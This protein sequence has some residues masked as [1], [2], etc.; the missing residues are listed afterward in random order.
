[1]KYPTDTIFQE[2]WWLDAVAPGHW[3]RHE[4]FDGDQLIAWMPL[5][6]RPRPLGITH[7]GMPPLTQTL[8][9]WIKP[10]EGSSMRRVGKI[11]K[12]T[13]ELLAT[14]PNFDYF[15]QNACHTLE[16]T[17]PFHWAG[18]EAHVK[19]TYI[20]DKLNDLDWLWTNMSAR[21][22]RAI[23]KAQNAIKVREL[24]DFGVFKRLYHNTFCRQGMETP[25]DESVLDRAYAAAKS[26]NAVKMLVAEDAS[27]RAHGAVFL[28]YDSRATYYLMGGSDPEKRDSQSLSLLLWESIKFSSTV[29]Q[30]FD[31]EGSM[32]E[33]IE[34]FFRNFGAERTLYYGLTKMSTR[35]SVA[36]G[37]R[38]MFQKLRKK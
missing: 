38:S 16:D 8:G 17:L 32:I 30:S 35:F 33:N 22:R 9:P 23:R 24:K 21:T 11:H 26:N 28:L 2:A 6:Q 37:A 36:W 1:M 19:Y 14:L 34:V 25:V 29:S 31:F 12:H 20:L 18:F 13:S 5:V 10:V 4:L 15:S 3:E 7:F 27:G